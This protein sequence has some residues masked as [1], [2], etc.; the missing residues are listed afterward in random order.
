[1]RIAIIGADGQLGSDLTKI[2]QDSTIFPLFYPD[3]DITKPER[4]KRILFSL[5]PEIIINTAAYHNV[6]E[7][8]ANPLKSFSVNSIAVKELVMVCREL[9]AVFVHFSTDYVFD[10]EKRKPYIEE[11]SPLPLN[12]YG[13]SKLSGEYFI[14]AHLKK[15]FL[16]R[17]CGLYGDSDR[18]GTSFVS[19]I[20]ALER[21]GKTLSIVNDQW[22]TPTSTIDLAKKVVMLLQSSYYGLYHLT[23][24]G[25]CTWFE[26]AEA[27]FEMLKKKPRLVSV[28]SATYGAKARRPFYSVLENRQAKKMGFSGMMH[29]KTALENY[30]RRKS[31]V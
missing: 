3:F 8:E 18:F 7:C 6:D 31:L 24:E 9:N 22:V 26:F 30:I 21:K 27:I 5:N 19:K 4:T 11:D 1:M 15:H 29:W 13:V 25:Q 12:L 20:L 23:S 10:G 2:L 17:S 28:D 14:R 16:I